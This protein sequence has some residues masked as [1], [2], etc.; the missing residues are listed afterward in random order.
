MRPLLDLGRKAGALVLYPVA[1][2]LAVLVA[3]A[4][5]LVLVGIVLPIFATLVGAD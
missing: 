4:W 1:L 3:Y 5:L 2:L